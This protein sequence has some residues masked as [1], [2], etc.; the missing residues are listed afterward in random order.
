MDAHYYN[1]SDDR[2]LASGPGDPQRTFRQH[3]R[4]LTAKGN[5]AAMEDFLSYYSQF[6]MLFGSLVEE[7][8]KELAEQTRVLVRLDV[9]AGELVE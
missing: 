8:R 9:E 5:R 7:C 2:D 6:P 3:W 1:G 4:Y